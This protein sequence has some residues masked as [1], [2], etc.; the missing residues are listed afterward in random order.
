MKNIFLNIIFFFALQNK[1][2]ILINTFRILTNFSRLQ[3]RN[4]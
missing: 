3:Y 1:S 2:H 4:D